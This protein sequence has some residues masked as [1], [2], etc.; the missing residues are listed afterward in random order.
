MPKKRKKSRPRTSAKPGTKIKRFAL[1]ILIISIIAFLN[2]TDYLSN[3]LS[4]LFKKN[5]GFIVCI[6]PGHGAYDTGTKSSDGI[7]EKNIN[8]SVGL[9]VGQILENNNIKVVYTRNDDATILGS[10][11][12]EDLEKRVQISRDNNAY[13]FVS[14]H[15]NSC[16]NPSIKGIELWCN[17]RN[18]QGDLLAKGIRDQ[19]FKLNYTTERAIKYRDTSSLYVLRNTTAIATL[20]EIGYLSNVNDKKFISSEIGQSKCANAIANAILEFKKNNYVIPK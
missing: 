8:L 17:Q 7:L 13:I 6:D 4:S 2:T 16:K 14:I 11:E 15:C 1:S 3:Y 20:V 19:L 9:K 10:T 18:T 12:N 5:Q